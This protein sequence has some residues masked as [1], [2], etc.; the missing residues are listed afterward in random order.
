MKKLK[1]AIAGYGIVGK[2]RHLYINENPN[3]EIVAI[4]DNNPKQIAIK[5]DNIL[6]YS[7]YDKML[8]LNF[9]ILFVCLVN[10]VAA[11]ATIKGLKKGCHVFCE[12]PPGMNVKEIEEVIAVEK[13]HPDLKLKYGFNHRYH[14]SV[15]KALDIIKSKEIGEIIHMR[16]VYGKSKI[17][18]FSGG[19]RSKRELAGGGILLDQGIH[20]L[21]L[22]RLFSGDFIQIKSF[23]SNKYWGHDVEDNAYALLKDIK[24]RVSM[25]NSSATQWQHK[26]TLEITLSEGFIVLDGVLSGSKSY[27]DEKIIIGKRDK[28][29]DTG[30]M[31]FIEN[32]FLV[33][34]SWKKEIDEFTNAILYNKKIDFGSSQDALE[35]M[36]L[37]FGIYYD[38]KEWSKKYNLTNQIKNE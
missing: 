38:D 33:D 14:D 21:D 26:F 20:M 7:D 1:V 6:V 19:W 10:N 28:V 4:S 8:E 24:G 36:R 22:M 17:I 35:T 15:E 29:S 34:N 30:Q 3:L 11:D 31:E 23:V 5:D 18:P 16:G 25:L 2:K 13:Q 32:K 9:D 37:V 27:G 12:K